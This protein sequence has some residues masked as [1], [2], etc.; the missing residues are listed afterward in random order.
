MPRRTIA[1]LITLAL[2]VTPLIAD[3]QQPTKVYRIGRLASGSPPEVS[4]FVQRTAEAFRQGLRELGYV[5]SQNLVMTWRFA[6]GRLERLPELAA[7]LV[8]LPVDVLV[9]SGGEPVIRA[10]QHATQTIPIVFAGSSDPVG[11][12]FVASLAHP[13]GNITGLTTFSVELLGK[14]LELLKELVPTVARI[15]ILAN[16]ANPGTVY[17]V[18]EAQASAH[19]LGVQP[20]VIEVRSLDEFESAFAAMTGADTGALLVLTDPST[21]EPHMSA[22]VALAQRSRLPTMYPWRSYMEA[23]G[24][25][26]YGASLPDIHRR[27]AI[28][29]DKILKGAKPADL[30]VEQPTKFELVI[31][32]KTAQALGLTIPPS[33]LFQADEVIR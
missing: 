12:G 30:P 14:R 5:E 28:Y 17:A 10:A 20:H 19:A 11:R 16:P 22:I 9:V 8:Q 21:F 6:E 31:N 27:A 3:A 13:G 23:G 18:R 4:P 24:L 25:M 32:L 7:E 1:L 26:V 29:V 33:L 2:L 15:A